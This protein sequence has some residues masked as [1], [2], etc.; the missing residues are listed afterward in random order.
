LLTYLEEEFPSY[1]KREVISE[2]ALRRYEPATPL[3]IAHLSHGDPGVRAAAAAYFTKIKN[4]S[5][6]SSLL[7]CLDDDDVTVREW[8]YKALVLHGDESVEEIRNLLKAAN[9]ATREVAVTLLGQ[10]KTPTSEE[11]LIEALN[12]RGIAKIVFGEPISVSAVAI[13]QLVK[14]PSL[15]AVPR[16]VELLNDKDRSVRISAIDAARD[17]KIQEAIPELIKMLDSEDMTIAQKAHDT[18]IYLVGKDLGA[19]S[20][21][22]QELSRER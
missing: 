8:A 14:F 20:K 11:S 7:K 21:S 13:R 19:S 18:L 6:I 10:I 5:A 9:P 22:W 12:D 15:R 16:F 1:T 17:L 3:V 4:V 2:L